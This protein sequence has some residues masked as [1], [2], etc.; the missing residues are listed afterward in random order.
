MA[1]AGVPVL[2]G[3]TNADQSDAALAA[4]ADA[5]GYP[6]MVKPAAGGGG[7]GMRIV[8][9][10][11]ELAERLASARREALSSFGDD[12]LLIE[13]Y[14]ENPRHI[15]VQIFGDNH[16]DAVHLFERDC[17]VQRRH[18]KV[19]ER[20][21]AVYLDEAGRQA[22]CEAGLKIARAAGYRNAGTAEFL[23]SADTGDIYFIEVNPRIQVE[24]TVT[25]W[26]TGIDLVQAQLRIAEGA[27]IGDEASGVP[28]Q[29]DIRLYG[30]AIQCRVTTE[31]PENNFTPDYGRLTAYRS[32]AGFGIRLD[33][34]T[35]FSGALIT[36]YYDSLLV[37]V[38]SWAPN[39]PVA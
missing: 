20:A 19:I 2:P 11:G 5:A 1:A 31:D 28:V 24:H 4:A 39:R 8:R 22:L 23:Q 18:Q 32:A 29:E 35:A 38:T 9:A 16:G 10:A 25:D 27:A 7:R 34:G 36:R 14:L 15:E 12:T 17:T 30:H 33:A 6:V 13:K 26:V 3:G 21:P 37:K